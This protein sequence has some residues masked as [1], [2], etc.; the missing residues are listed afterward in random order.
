MK[1]WLLRISPCPRIVG[2]EPAPRGWL[3][4]MR[5]IYD[6]ELVIFTGSDYLTGID[7][8]SG[9]RNYSCPSGSFLIVPPGVRHI[10]REAAGRNGHRYWVHFDWEYAGDRS[11]TPLITYCPAPPRAEHFRLAP[12]YVPSE[13]FRGPVRDLPAVLALLKRLGL[14]WNSDRRRDQTVSRGLLLELLLELLTPDAE[15]NSHTRDHSSRLAS[16]VRGELNRLGQLPL[17]DAPTVKTCLERG[18]ISY[19]HQCRVF[20]EHYG[21]SPLQYVNELRMAKIKNMLRNSSFSISEVAEKFG[22][23]N[24]GY[25]SRAFRRYTGFSPSEYRDSDN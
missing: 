20:K 8:E 15:E 14:L 7:S 2:N 21:I 10:S 19:A 4:A 22:Y 6:H 9:V 5:V 25:F 11:L 18:G 23:D 13:V 12:S 1:E 24:P 16:R 3:E 17:R